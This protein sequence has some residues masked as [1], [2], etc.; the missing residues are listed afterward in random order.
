MRE[1]TFQQLSDAVRELC[2]QANTILPQDLRVAICKAME[3]EQSGVGRAILGDLRENYEFAQAKGL[4]RG[5]LI[6]RHA[7]RNSLVPSITYIANT[8]GGLLG[9]S[10]ITE[11]VFSVPGI[12]SYA[13]TAINNRDYIAI[14]GYV[15][16]TGG[17]G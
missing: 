5:Q 2:I 14:Q 1:V 8:F 6:S 17:S 16:F 7:L 3:T 15:L 10:M 4:R 9:G 11:S 13:L 12:G